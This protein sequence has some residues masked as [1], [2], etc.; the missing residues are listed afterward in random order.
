VIGIFGGTFDPIH[1]GHLRPAVEV[2]QGLG[3]AQVRFVPLAEPVHRQRPTASAELRLAMV[4]A[5]IAGVPGFIADDREIRRQG[6]SYTL[7]TLQEL[8]SEHPGT[9]LCLC[10]GGDAFAEFLTWH[11]PLAILELAHLIVMGRPGPAQRQ[12]RD[13]EELARSRSVRSAEELRRIRAGCIYF[14]TVTQLDISAT[15]IRALIAEHRDARFLL[16]ND[17]IEIILRHRLYA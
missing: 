10:V 6:G 13:L 16:P 7:D 5:A 12:R 17:V 11:R 9:R 2:Q 15:A 4:R 14:Q 8:A 3:L 1:Y